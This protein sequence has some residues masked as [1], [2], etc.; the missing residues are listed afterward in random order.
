MANVADSPASP[1][2]EQAIRAVVTEYSATWNRHDMG[3][4]AELFTDD[5]H[6]VNIVG[7]HWRGKTAV[8]TGHEEIH[9]TFFHKT[10]IGIAGVELRTIAPGVAAAV[11]LLKVGPFTPP[12]GVR[13]PESEDR[14]SLVLTKRNGRWRITHGHNTV[15]DPA[16]RPFNPINS[17]RPHGSRKPA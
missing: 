15:I 2:D 13:R 9:S 17:E 12:D 8:V 10:E 16:A 5:A 1:S 7:W 11:V 3:A 6:W 4:M 14:L